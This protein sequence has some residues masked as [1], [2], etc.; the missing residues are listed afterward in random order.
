LLRRFGS[1]E[2]ENDNKNIERKKKRRRKECDF[3]GERKIIGK[4]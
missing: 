3:W 1:S 2:W 4:K